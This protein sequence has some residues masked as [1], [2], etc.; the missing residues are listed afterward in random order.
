MVSS[1][2]LSRK[3]AAAGLSK[4]FAVCRMQ[5]AEGAAAARAVQRHRCQ[6]AVDTKV[7]KENVNTKAAREVKGNRNL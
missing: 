2:A 3:T 1:T 5:A 7:S 6:T 4:K